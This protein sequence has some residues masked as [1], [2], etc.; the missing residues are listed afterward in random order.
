MLEQLNQCLNQKN[1]INPQ[2]IIK[3]YGADAVRI[4]I[5]SDS[6]PEKDVQWSEQGMVASYKFINKF[7]LLNE[8]LT[9]IFNK[10]PEGKNDDIEIFVNKVINKIELALEN[11]K[12]NLI[13]AVFHEIYTFLFNLTKD[14]K[15]YSNLNNSYKKILIVMTPIVPHLAN[16]CLSKLGNE[17][18]FNWPKLEK[19]FL[20]TD[21]IEVVIQINGKKEI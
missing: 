19:D 10:K 16:E 4:F 14:S 2:D 11:F 12:Y 8:K 17:K 21:N 7:W 13:I 1:T 3:N 20:V 15:N 5:L 6:P 18:D 9:Q